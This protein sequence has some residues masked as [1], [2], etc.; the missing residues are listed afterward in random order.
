LFLDSFPI[1]GDIVLSSGGHSGGSADRFTHAYLMRDAGCTQLKK[2][3]RLEKFQISF[4]YRFGDSVGKTNEHF[5]D[6]YSTYFG[7][8]RLYLSIN[9][10]IPFFLKCSLPGT[11][12]FNNFQFPVDFVARIVY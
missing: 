9:T 10:I 5:S 3:L 2:R 11:V 7:H 1:G 8:L 6:F 12:D 4:F